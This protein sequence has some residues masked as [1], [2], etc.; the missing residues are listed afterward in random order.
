M[1]KAVNYKSNSIVYFKGDINEKI[2]IFV[3]GKV[4]QIELWRNIDKGGIDGSNESFKRKN[5][6]IDDFSRSC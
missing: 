3:I 1:P 6:R 2:Y 4:I 5:A